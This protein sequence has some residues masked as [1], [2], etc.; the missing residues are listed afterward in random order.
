MP[1]ARSS[2]AVAVGSRPKLNTINTSTVKTSVE[3]NAV[4][5][6][7]SITRSLRAMSHA[8]RS[9]S[10]MT[11]RPPVRFGDLGRAAPRPRRVFHKLASHLE[12]DLRRELGALL[13]VVRGDDHRA[14]GR[15]VIREQPPE[16]ACRG[17]V[18]TGERLIQQ[19]Y[20][21]LMHQRARDRG[22]LRQSA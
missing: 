15:R 18:E 16:V 20:G 6:R 19:Q 9:R 2:T 12:C 5:L 14:P 7:S 8:W 1:G 13:H 3:T 17:E 21:G 11:H 4:R 10:D 22:A